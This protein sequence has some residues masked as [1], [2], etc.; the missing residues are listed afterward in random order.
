MCEPT[1]LLKNLGTEVTFAAQIS[2]LRSLVCYLVL[3]KWPVYSRNSGRGSLERYSIGN[4]LVLTVDETEQ[5]TL[6]V[7]SCV[8]SEQG[9]AR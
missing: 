7:R 9:Q 3:I 1:T 4:S 6:L 5:R 8:G 2:I